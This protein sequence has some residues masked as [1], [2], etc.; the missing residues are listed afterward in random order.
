MILPSYHKNRYLKLW[1]DKTV[2]NLVLW[3]KRALSAA[4]RNWEVR[5]DFS[6]HKCANHQTYYLI[7]E[8]L[9]AT[10]AHNI[11]HI[12]LCNIEYVIYMTYFQN[13]TKFIKR[14][15]PKIPVAQ[16]RNYNID[17]IFGEVFCSLGAWWIYQ[18]L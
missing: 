16:L 5:L 18:F 11:Y 2:L 6:I 9:F 15:L 4:K 8:V 12:K 17:L 13:W 14:N 1:S 7:T 3:F 10:A